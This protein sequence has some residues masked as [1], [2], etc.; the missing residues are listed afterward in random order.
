M[1]R[2]LLVA[3][4]LGT[5]TAFA[6]EVSGLVSGSLI[7]ALT[8]IERPE[9]GGV[10]AYVGEQNAPRAFA[11]ML[12][13]DPDSLKK[14]SAKLAKDIK[15]AGGTTAWDHEA[16]ANIV[17]FVSSGALGVKRPKDKVLKPINES[18][19]SPVKELQDI[20]AKR[21]K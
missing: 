3:V 17:T 11:D 20:V 6:A 10:F 12:A 14:Y 2:L 19:L 1:I 7:E 9:L 15:S 16:C 8:A 5:S 18:V 4:I 21:G 13:R